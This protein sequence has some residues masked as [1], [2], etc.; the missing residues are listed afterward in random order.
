MA[1]ILNPK[2]KKSIIEAL[3]NITIAMVLDM[4]HTRQDN[5]RLR[6]TS[7][8][9][10]N[11]AFEIKAP[12]E[13]KKNASPFNANGEAW[14]D[15]KNEGYGVGAFQLFAYLE[16]IDPMADRDL[17]LQK[18]KDYFLDENYQ[19][20]LEK[21]ASNRK[22]YNSNFVSNNK[23][24]GA[25]KKEFIPPQRYD[26]YLSEGINY[27][28]RKRGIPVELI[29]R[30]L[31]YSDG[32]IYVTKTL[33]GDKRVAF[34]G[35]LNS[36]ERSISEE[37]GF[38]GA[39]EGSNRD[40]SGFEV[41]GDENALIFDSVVEDGEEY[42]VIKKNT[43]YFAL[44]E[45]AIDALSYNAL[46]PDRFVVSTNGCGNFQ[47]QYAKTV[48]YLDSDQGISI[49]VAFD[50]DEAGEEAA[51]KLFNAI[52]VRM[53]LCKRYED[54]LKTRYKHLITEED[55]NGWKKPVDEWILTQKISFPF[56]DKNDLRDKTS[57]HL[58]FFNNP[59][60][61]DQGYP[62]YEKN[63][64]VE[65][66]EYED[67]NGNVKTRQKRRVDG[68]RVT[69][70][71]EKATIHFNVEQEIADLLG[72]NRQVVIKV[73][74]ENFEKIT[75]E[76]LVR[77]KPIN[78]KDWN[79]VLNK[80]GISYITEYSKLFKQGFKE[81]G[82]I[83][84]P[85]LD[86]T[87]SP[88]SF[89]RYRDIRQAPNIKQYFNT[90]EQTIE[91]KQEVKQVGNKL[92]PFF[93]EYMENYKQRRSR[94]TFA[95]D[96]YEEKI[97]RIYSSSMSLDKKIQNQQLNNDL[98]IQQENANHND[99]ISHSKFSVLKKEE[100]VVTTTPV[101][102]TPIQNVS[103]DKKETL[104][105]QQT[106]VQK[107]NNSNSTSTSSDM[108][109]WNELEQKGREKQSKGFLKMISKA[110]KNGNQQQ[111]ISNDKKED[112]LPVIGSK[113]ITKQEVSKSEE[114]TT[115]EKESVRQQQELQE[116]VIQKAEV[117]QVSNLKDSHF[118]DYDSEMSSYMAYMEEE[119]DLQSQSEMAYDDYF[120]QMMQQEE[121]QQKSFS[122]LRKK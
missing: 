61:Q 32:K 34:V 94:F 75:S 74:K 45:A 35:R 84:F 91:I 119:Q 92:K 3:P 53:V 62:V 40:L 60:Y 41:A 83:V 17:V 42:E 28:N 30:S 69:D 104:Q 36:E 107:T 72:M 121:T 70:K 27:L 19:V 16:N 15:F 21:I 73:K 77:E 26:E 80:Q 24:G 20:D 18:I 71:L 55:P 54:F 114:L 58:M 109:S 102:P 87:K 39:G 76:M 81:N 43:G 50:S 10:D 110:N 68:I 98:H 48:G 23:G 96:L 7:E 38:K 2:E 44:T 37:F 108:M 8:Y 88:M 33:Y 120:S 9:I 67:N 99:N 85:K 59:F 66:V 65:E 57:P 118:N 14:R 1:Q 52:Y 86:D 5:L 64:I 46:F 12:D 116:K 11:G 89:Y 95:N 51:Q 122:V 93:A 112:M 56:E 25:E 105:K 49:R 101:K 4:Y 82:E 79:E 29:E 47:L 111:S 106:V 90:T 115:I 78:E 63:E 117:E 6:V 31:N 103:Y 100:T 13:N 113:K 97:S 22:S